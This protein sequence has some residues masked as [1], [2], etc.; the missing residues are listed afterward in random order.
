MVGEEVGGGLDDV[1]G[2]AVGEV[3]V[4]RGLLEEGDCGVL[5]VEL[6]QLVK[7]ADG[8]LDV[9]W[10]VVGREEDVVVL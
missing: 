5:K 8:G 4:R 2:E 1:V 7:A 10:E 6:V 9:V 3:A